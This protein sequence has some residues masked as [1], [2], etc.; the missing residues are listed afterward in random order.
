MTICFS[1]TIHRPGGWC[2]SVPCLVAMIVGLVVVIGLVLAG[3][4][5]GVLVGTAGTTTTVSVRGPDKNEL[6]WHVA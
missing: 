6:Q 2:D 5:A 3:I 4:V 1:V